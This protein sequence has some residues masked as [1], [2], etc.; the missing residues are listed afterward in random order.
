MYFMGGDIP[1]KGEDVT[2]LGLSFLKILYF[3]L[4]GRERHVPTPVVKVVV[5]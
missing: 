2:Y 5:A 1:C 3:Y 4:F